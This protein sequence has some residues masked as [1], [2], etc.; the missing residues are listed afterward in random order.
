MCVE[1]YPVY[2]SDLS[3]GSSQAETLGVEV[4]GEPDNAPED[5]AESASSTHEL[6]SVTSSLSHHSRA[7][8]KTAAEVGSPLAGAADV[9]SPLTGAAEVSEVQSW[10]EG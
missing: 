7:T 5:Q 6:V 2:L 10:S 8:N 1:Q 4:V 9:G 3:H